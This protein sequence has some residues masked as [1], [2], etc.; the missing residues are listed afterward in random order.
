MKDMKDR[1]QWWGHDFRCSL[2]LDMNKMFTKVIIYNIISLDSQ[3]LTQYID[4]INNQI[5]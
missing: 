1:N 5:A 2:S 4:M 3:L